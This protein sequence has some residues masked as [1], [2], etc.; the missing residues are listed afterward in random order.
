MRRTRASCG[1]S[2]RGC[3]STTSSEWS[4][5]RSTDDS[6]LELNIYAIYKRALVWNGCLENWCCQAKENKSVRDP[7][8][9]NASNCE[10]QRR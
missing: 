6:V 4:D 7:L 2:A 10:D 8:V 9:L 3:S 5:R 1:S